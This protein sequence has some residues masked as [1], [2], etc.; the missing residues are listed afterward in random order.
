MENIV[1]YISLSA[2]I[3]VL[4]ACSPNVTEPSIT[5]ADRLTWAQPPTIE[6]SGLLPDTAYTLEVERVSNWNAEATERSSLI[7]ISDEKGA[8]NT[9]TQSAQD[10]ELADPYRPIRTMSYIEDPL[11]DL[12]QGQLRIIVK[13][14]DAITVQ[15]SVAIGPDTDTLSEEPL[16]DQFP[17]AFILKQKNI[18]SPRPTI[19]VLGGSE[20]GDGA[21]RASAPLFAQEGY[22]V[23]GLP[24]YSPAW[25]GNEA[26][27]KDLP[28][29]FAELRVDYLESAVAA[30]RQR[31]DVDAK[32]IQLIGG[33]KGAEYVLLAGSLI[34][35][36][37]AGGGFCGIVAD[38]PSDVV[39][40]GWGAGSDSGVTSG[41]SWRGEA[42]PFVPYV[43]MGK[44]LSARRTG[45]KYTMIEAH[46]N[47]RA[48][49]P[50]RAVA[51]RIKVENID[52]PVFLIG[53]GKD[54]VWASGQMVAAITQTRQT[55]GLPTQSYIYPEGGHGVSGTPL[56]RT[57]PADNLARRE[58]FPALMKFLKANSSSKNCRKAT[59]K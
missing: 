50:D 13:S 18:T 27:F 39:W 25:F 33:S 9:A 20:G 5:V 58:N 49:F 12:D 54:T 16:G 52:E 4:A 29:G 1:K 31:K 53:G 42:L 36:D 38:V 8:I 59:L 55:K 15:R 35:D 21:A 6:V 40:E 19:V 7:Y 51:A 17:G 37:S 45:G 47:G 14:G 26:Q 24:Y 10:G 32:S 48:A 30:L 28:Q 34:A 56:A 2:V 11:T 43:D 44:A 46:E 41:F 22:I 3:L 23:L 57:Q